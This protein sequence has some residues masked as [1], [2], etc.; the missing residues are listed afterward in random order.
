[1]FGMHQLSE[2]ELITKQTDFTDF[3]EMDWD[4]N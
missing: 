2:T 3:V 1:M 4:V